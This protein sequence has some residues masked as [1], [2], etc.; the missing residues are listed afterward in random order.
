MKTSGTCLALALCLAAC[1]SVTTAGDAG[2]D[3]AAN[4]PDS[5]PPAPVLTGI[6]PD[7]GLI[8]TE[9]TLTGSNFGATQGSSSV[10]VGG[11]AA[12]VSTWTDAEIVA[13][14]PVDAFPG[15]RDVIVTTAAG[16]SAPQV[17]RVILPPMVYLNNDTSDTTLGGSNTITVLTADPATGALAQAGAPIAMG[18]PS[19]GY[20]GCSTSAIV[21]EGTRRLFATGNTAVAVFDID[22]LSGALTPVAG[23]PF[24]GGTGVNQAYGLAINAAG[25]RLF[26]AD[27]SMHIVVYD[28]AADGTLTH[29]SGSPFATPNDV[30]T[31]ILG[32][33]ERFVYGNS[34]SS[35]FVGYAVGATGAL[36]ALAGSP[37]AIGAFSFQGARRPGADQLFIPDQTPR[38]NVWALDPTSGLPTMISG[39]PFAVTGVTG[40]LHYN[41]FTPDGARMY[42]GVNG[43]GQIYGYSLDAAGAP[44]LL[45]GAPWLFSSTAPTHS[46]LSVSRGGR[47]LVGAVENNK[48]VAVYALDA[49][50]TPIQVAGSPFTQ[51]TTA[52][53][54]SGMA[55]TF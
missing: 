52:E 14:I 42:V 13:S 35:V 41:T 12:D 40:T 29:V 38:I 43:S 31:L 16:S 2:D 45:A 37:F 48:K 15:E 28:V 39:S 54:V 6:A 27:F 32:Q 19:T 26:V 36:T 7:T 33:D 5:G 22:P 30:D 55:I 8:L 23:S 3:D 44:T 4:P 46:C 18:V 17:F 24:G 53:S 21:H 9:V 51:T 20:G 10:T 47:F 11:V 34:E 49:A 1:G 50:G 25:T